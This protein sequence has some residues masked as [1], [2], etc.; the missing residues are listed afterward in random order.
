LGSVKYFC[1]NFSRTGKK[2]RLD[3]LLFYCYLYRKIKKKYFL[4]PIHPYR[5]DSF[6]VVYNNWKKSRKYSSKNDFA[7]V[8]GLS[9]IAWKSRPLFDENRVPPFWS[10]SQTRIRNR[11]TKS[12]KRFGIFC[13]SVDYHI[14]P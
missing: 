6:L 11:K 3:P 8:M 13:L 4:G 5:K 9:E 2:A 7:L 10:D 1:I 12:G 14:L